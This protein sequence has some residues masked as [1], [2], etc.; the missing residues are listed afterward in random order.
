MGTSTDIPSIISRDPQSNFLL[1]PACITLD[2]GKG[3]DA[4]CSAV[5]N[6]DDLRRGGASLSLVARTI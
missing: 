5:M 6:Y 3:K 1:W 2:K 4:D